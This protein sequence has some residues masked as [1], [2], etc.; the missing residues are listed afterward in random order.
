MPRRAPR[1]PV[2]VEHDVTVEGLDPAHD[3]VRIAHLSDIHVGNLTPAAHVRAAVELASGAGADV[4]ALTGDYVCWRKTEVGMLREQLAGLRA[5]RVVATLGNHD[6][7]TS[8]SGVRGAL[9]SHGYEVLGNRHTSLDVRGA[10]LH[11]I[12]V[13]DPVTRHHDLDR[14]FDGVPAR[15]TRVVLCHCPEQAPGLA[16]RGADLVLSGHTHGGQI[17]LR[18]VTDRIIERMGKRYRRGFY[19]LGR[20][21]L[22]VTPGVGFS[23]LRVR[24]GDGTQSEVALF[25]LRA[26]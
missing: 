24:V 7:F 9:G 26:A 20:G 14:A 22:Y 12:G 19:D 1:P 6:Y 25:T 21:Q 8:A 5:T 10:P 4:I 23:G 15:G 13:D 16:E 18:G 17:Y 2:L 11:L 3:G